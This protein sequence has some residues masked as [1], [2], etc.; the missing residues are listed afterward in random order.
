MGQK[1]QAIRGMNDILPQQT[2]LWQFFENK[3]AELAKRY[4]YQ[5]IRLP[6]LE[7]TALFAR[8]VGEVTDIVEKE[9]YTFNDRSNESL[10]LRPEGT[11]GCV[12]AALQHGLLHNQI[13]K[14]WYMGPIFRYERPQKGRYRQFHQIGFEAFGMATAEIDVELIAMTAALWRSLGLSQY[15]RLEL[16]SLGSFEERQCYREKLITYY[17]E[18]ETELDE[19]SK[20]RLHKNPMRILDSKNPEMKVINNAAPKLLDELG[21]ESKA[22]FERV[23]KLLDN[24]KIDYIVNPTIVRGL[25]YYCHTVFEWT[26][27]KLGA[28]GTVCA[29]G[30][31]DGLVEELGGKPTPA[32]GFAM[33]VERVL[34]L[35]QS[36][37]LTPVLAAMAD[38]YFVLLGEAPSAKG[39]EL[40]EDLRRAKPEMNVATDCTQA[41]FKAQLKRADQSGAAIAIIVGEDELAQGKVT[42]KY[43]REDKPQVV[44]NMADMLA[45]I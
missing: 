18:H 42:L 5:E 7:K 21:A 22:H 45:S 36:L 20:K 32:V 41:S 13:Q 9:M 2:P 10:T 30:R 17:T 33:G 14:V 19:D 44:I 26:T 23:C 4:V 16:N 38:V 40:A 27:D 37:E 15:L 24:L 11:A 39:L 12:R 28:Q 25:D 3:V 1:I 31:Y 6:V 8:S 34:E 35:L 43:L 29:G